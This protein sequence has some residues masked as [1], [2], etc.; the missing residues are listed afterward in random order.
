MQLIVYTADILSLI[1]KLLK[2][3]ITTMD[4]AFLR[5]LQLNLPSILSTSQ[6]KS[7][8]AI[9]DGLRHVIM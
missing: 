1:E 6:E 3:N 5:M 8:T 4:K 9:F 2:I 7:R